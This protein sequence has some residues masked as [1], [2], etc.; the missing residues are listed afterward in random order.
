MNF[1]AWS[2]SVGIAA[3]M[4]NV[5]EEFLRAILTNDMQVKEVMQKIEA[6]KAE[7]GAT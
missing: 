7:K 1:N 4:G 3:A 6:K 5:S 2:V